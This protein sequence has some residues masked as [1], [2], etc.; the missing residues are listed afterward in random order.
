MVKKLLINLVTV[1]WWMLGL[2]NSIA[3]QLIGDSILTLLLKTSITYFIV[4]LILIICN[5]PRGKL[6]HLI[7]K[8]LFWIVGFVVVFVLNIIAGL[9]FKNLF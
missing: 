6:G 5:I 1:F 9:V 2:L 8:T 3:L 4:G 7:G